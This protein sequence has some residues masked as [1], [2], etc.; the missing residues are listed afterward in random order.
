[1]KKFVTTFLLL[2]LMLPLLAQNPDFDR[3]YESAR[4][5]YSQGQYEK[6]RTAIR[7]TLKNL[8]SL[9]ATQIQQ[10]NQ[11]ISQCDQ[12]IAN[13][14]RL[15]L[16]VTT[17]SLPFGSGLDSVS[18]VAAKPTQVTASSSA[19][20]WCQVEKVTGSHVFLRTQ[21]NPNKAPRTAQVTVAMGKIK[22]RTFTV[23]QEARPETVKQVRISTRPNR[24][25]LMVDG[26]MAI[27]GVWEGKLDAGRHR[28]RAEKSGYFPKDTVITVAD[29]MKDNQM[30]FSIPLVPTFGRIKLEVVPQEG[31]EFKEGYP[32]ELTINGRIVEKLNYSYDDDR[33]IE[34]Y[35]LYED[36]TVPVPAGRVSIVA[37]ADSYERELR[38]IQVNAGEEVPVTLAL[39]AKAGRLSIIDAGQARDAKVFVDGKEL[40]TVQEVTAHPLII[41]EHVI[42]L[43]KPGFAPLE[44][45]YSISMKENDDVSLNIAMYR[46][47]PYVF[48]STPSDARVFVNGEHIGNTPTKPV[49]LKEL[50]PG[51]TYEVE[52]AKEGFLTRKHTISPDFDNPQ[53]VSL[54]V[55]LFT[56]HKLTVAG[57]EPN[58]KLFVWNR[59]DGDSTLVDGALLP[60]DIS[61]PLR[62]EPYY[63][64]LHR[65]G[66][67]NAVF[68]KFLLFNDPEANQYKFRTWGGGATILAATI[69]LLGPDNIEVGSGSAAGSKSFKN[70]G[71]LRLVNFQMVPGLST[72]VLRGALFMGKDKAEFAG[73][74]STSFKVSNAQYL[75]SISPILL[76]WDFRVGG[77]VMDYADVNLLASYAWY[78]PVWKQMLGFSH[79]SGHDIFLG[80]EAAT[81][82]HYVNLGLKAGWQMYPGLTAHLYNTNGGKTDV[83]DNYT[84]CPV[85]VP[86]MFV[87]GLELSLGGK[88]KSIWRVFY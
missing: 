28:I 69:H 42:T 19:P 25:R 65:I 81:R 68:K 38:E 29:D 61:L 86:G 43:E 17:L 21:M 77:T 5:L 57:D 54:S 70:F 64:E 58:L 45:S 2:A 76:N 6:A 27:T 53:E 83:K 79:I 49:L 34:R 39:K 7:N 56:T 51:Q 50:E 48:D 26:G 10:G 71:S 31:F 4:T 23:T 20:A 37:S 72:S 41:G 75:P 62:E 78:L 8:P 82:V 12:A 13:R 55:P 16:S 36:S 32:Y 15:D 52:I 59:K 85:S 40:G 63:M 14:D 67:K 74:S 44:T 1:M 22:K 35:V 11:L 87:I 73:G 88:G 30:D 47:V 33:D 66:R 84:D 9:S 80:L 46:Y 18:F 24:G 3:K 60:A